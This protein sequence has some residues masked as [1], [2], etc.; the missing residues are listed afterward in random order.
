MTTKS[1]KSTTKND[2]RA[3]SNLHTRDIAG[4]PTS[5]D[6]ETRSFDIVIT[7]ETPVTQ[8]V[9]DPSDIVPTG[10]VPRYIEVG[11]VLLASG[12]DLSR[13]HRMHFVDSHQTNDSIDRILG[14]IT[15]QRV[16]GQSVV[17]R[18]TLKRTRADLLDDMEDGI[19]GQISAG[20]CYDMKDTEIVPVE[21]GIPLLIV[22]RWTLTEASAVAVSADPN[23][24]VRSFNGGRMDEESDNNNN[25][26]EE[27]SM[28]IEEIVAAAEEAA[29]AASA[30]LEAAEEAVGADGTAEEMIERVKALRGTR[31]DEETTDNEG[32]QASDDTASEDEGTRAE[33]DEESQ[34]D[35]QMS[36]SEKRSLANIRTAAKAYGLDGYVDT[37]RSL[38]TPVRTI[39]ADIR[40]A[41]RERGAQST[42]NSQTRTAINPVIRNPEPEMPTVRSIYAQLNGRK[43]A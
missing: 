32:D 10:E 20:Y 42:S 36:E 11:E 9:R 38:R 23:A 33:G 31:M 22:K 15:D 18:V 40:K 41:V 34:D 8:W 24:F 27:K 28:N 37:L 5:I 21:G 14:K 1:R 30:A 13:A 35:D 3:E 43:T 26:I 7:T 6:K 39:E 29:S 16:E 2:T 25:K 19:Y 12:V 4:L 17:G